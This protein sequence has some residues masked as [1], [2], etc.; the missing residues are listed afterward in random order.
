[1]KKI[2]NQPEVET[3]EVQAASMLLDASPTGLPV[4][5]PLPGEGGD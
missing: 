2:Y 1:M 4:G 3:T 5:D